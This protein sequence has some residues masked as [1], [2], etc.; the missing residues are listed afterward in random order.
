MK[1]VVASVE[2]TAAMRVGVGDFLELTKPRIAVMALL[3]VAVGY[4]LGAA[5]F[6]RIDELLHTLLGTALVAGGA[7]ALNQLVERRS[8]AQMRRTA[9]RPLPS[10]RLQPPEVFLFGN[11]LSVVGIAYLA[12]A[13]PHPA[14]AIT[15]AVTLVI[16]VGV[17]TPLKTVTPLNTLVGAFP[18]AL[19]PVIG[20]CAARNTVGAEAAALFGILFVWQLPHFFAIAWIYRDDYTAGGHRMLAVGDRCGTRTAWS[21]MLTAAALLPVSLVPW[22]FATAGIPYLIGASLLG[23]WF[24]ATTVRFFRSRSD[25]AARQV[26]WASLLYLPGVLVLLVLDGLLPRYF[27]G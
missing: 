9:S 11:L 3:T 22:W 12:L 25:Q 20:W 16:Y 13:L 17:Y 19:P 15:A 18:G 21:M 26:L 4:L 27:G 24:L 6:L 14:A 8:D 1:T 7:S 2:E 23:L 10:G 5:P